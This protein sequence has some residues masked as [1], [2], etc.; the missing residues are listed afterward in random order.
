[1]TAAW[2]GTV[3]KCLAS[4]VFAMVVKLIHPLA[5]CTISI[6][7]LVSLV[8]RFY[9]YFLVV[10]YVVLKYCHLEIHYLSWL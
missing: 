8:K 3:Q 4:P 5:L 10:L 9:I 7:G 1:M 2:V 6:E